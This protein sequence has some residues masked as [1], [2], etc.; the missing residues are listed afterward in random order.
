MEAF[1][2]AP[3]P[4]ARNLK[5]LIWG[6]TRGG[7]PSTSSHR[8]GELDH[9]VTFQIKAPGAEKWGAPQDTEKAK[10]STFLCIGFCQFLP[11]AS[12]RGLGPRAPLILAERTAR[13][14]G[15]ARGGGRGTPSPFHV[16]ALPGALNLGPLIWGHWFNVVTWGLKS[17]PLKNVWGSY[18]NDVTWGLYPGALN[19]G[20]LI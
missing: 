19:I 20:P 14:G 5:P 12:T 13:I 17:G 3:L 8:A 9:Q 15:A 2:L 11:S 4:G 1:N 16:D 7:G 18:F 6:P 10:K